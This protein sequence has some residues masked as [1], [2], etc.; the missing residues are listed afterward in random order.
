[1]ISQP[2]FQVFCGRNP[3]GIILKRD[4]NIKD[5]LRKT[6]KAVFVHG[7]MLSLQMTNVYVMYILTFFGPYQQG[8]FII[9]LTL[10]PLILDLIES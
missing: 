1:M 6:S 7:F 4:I 8:T 10:T 3:Y 5:L 9:I 2:L